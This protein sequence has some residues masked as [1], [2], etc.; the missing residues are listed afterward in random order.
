MR[1]KSSVSQLLDG[2]KLGNN[3]EVTYFNLPKDLQRRKSWLAAN[4]RDKSKLP[5]NVF[6][7]SDHFEDKIF[8]NHGIYKTGLFTQ[9][10]Q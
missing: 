9:T 1:V 10:G 3:S 6:A 8:I 2:N 4:S 5:L 7:C